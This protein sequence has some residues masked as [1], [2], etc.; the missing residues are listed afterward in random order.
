LL[1]GISG[2]LSLWLAI[3]PFV[4]CLVVDVDYLFRPVLPITDGQVQNK[5]AQK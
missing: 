1:S 2:L 4:C 5:S 3:A